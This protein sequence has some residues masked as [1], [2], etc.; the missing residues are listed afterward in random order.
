MEVV[1]K[2]MKCARMKI[3]S[4]VIRPN[5]E[6]LKV[7]EVAITKNKDSDKKTHRNMKWQKK[8]RKN[9]ERQ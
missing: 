5:T 6:E 3:M 8:R 4:V 2:E 7:L 9:K 1:K